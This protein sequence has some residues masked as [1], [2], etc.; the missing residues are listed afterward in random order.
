MRCD[1]YQVHSFFLGWWN[2]VKL[3]VK[4]VAWFSEYAKNCNDMC[5]ISQW[6][7]YIHTY[8]YMCK[9]IHMCVYISSDEK[10]S[11]T[12]RIQMLRTAHTALHYL[13][14]IHPSC[15]SCHFL[16]CTQESRHT[17]WFAVFLIFLCTFSKVA[18]L[19][20]TSWFLFFFLLLLFFQ[21]SVK[22][23]STRSFSCTIPQG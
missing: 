14:C 20:R 3:I 11:M 2:V 9:L 10:S 5:I 1:C 22:I 17:K 16:I 8:M 13:A 7:M 18:F 4:I 19:P 6:S 12:W 23:A 21:N 15:I